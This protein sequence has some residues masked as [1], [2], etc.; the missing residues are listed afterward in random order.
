MPETLNIPS[1]W[2][3]GLRRILALLG[4]PAVVT[5]VEALFIVGEIIGFLIATDDDEDDED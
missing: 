4:H 2:E 5:A 1:G 3:V